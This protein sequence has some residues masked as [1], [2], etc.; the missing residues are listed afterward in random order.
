YVY[1]LG[2]AGLGSNVTSTLWRYDPAANSYLTLSP[3]TTAIDQAAAV[4]LDGVI[5]R[6]GGETDPQELGTTSTVE[7]Y[8]I[9]DNAWM[10]AANYP[11]A[12]YGISAIALDGYIFAAGGTS[13][14]PT[15][16]KTHRYD[17]TID[18][19]DDGPIADLP[20]PTSS[21]GSALYDGNWFLIEA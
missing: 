13:R 18:A 19:W 4:L 17:P 12:L 14:G 1:I 8:S 3:F 16:D 10:S 6:I 9:D 20:W 21:A 5:Y 7:A 11:I 2:G 15:R